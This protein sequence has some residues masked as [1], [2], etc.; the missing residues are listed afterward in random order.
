MT[1]PRSRTAAS[2][3]ASGWNL[4]LVTAF[5]SGF[6]LRAWQVDIQILLEDEWHA[7]H[8]LLRSSAL[9]IFTHLG[10]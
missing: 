8:K 10:H 4:L 1:A 7:I 5:V 6:A 9:D 3:F 2:S